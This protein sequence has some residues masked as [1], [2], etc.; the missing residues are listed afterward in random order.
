[1]K[2]AWKQIIPVF[3]LGLILG[4]ALGS[5]CHRVSARHF[6]KKPDHSSGMLEKFSKELNLDSNQK[7]AVKAALESSRG[8]MQAFRE[9]TGVKLNEIRAVMHSDIRKIL[10]PP[11][12]AEF[13]KLTAAW[14]KRHKKLRPEG[15][16]MR[17][18]RRGER[19]MRHEKRWAQDKPEDGPEGR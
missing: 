9:E 16:L 11:Q 13:D 19:G 5:W 14:E 1:M 12:Q 10:T 2:P 17:D 4:A 18:N 15:G 6:T 3:I 7:D 8:K